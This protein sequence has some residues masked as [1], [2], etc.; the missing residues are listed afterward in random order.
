LD[1]PPSL[2]RSVS[3]QESWI[4]PKTSLARLEAFLHETPLIDAVHSD[5]TTVVEEDWIGFRGC[6]FSWYEALPEDSLMHNFRLE[7]EDL[8]FEKGKIVSCVLSR[9]R[10]LS[11]SR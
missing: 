2:I 5:D 1:P 8:R 11:S 6:S 3:L 9:P 10:A 4:G 7:I